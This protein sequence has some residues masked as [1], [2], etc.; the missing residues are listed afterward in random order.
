M[1]E[2]TF[3]DIGYLPPP[4]RGN[5]AFAR[6]DGPARGFANAILLAVPLWGLIG[7]GIWALT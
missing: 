4:R 6:Q 1:R 5:D 3:T 2:A 7:L